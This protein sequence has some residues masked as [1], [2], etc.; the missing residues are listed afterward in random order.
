M[1]PFESRS[2]EASVLVQRGVGEHLMEHDEEEPCK[3]AHDARLLDGDCRLGRKLR[4][5]RH[6]VLSKGRPAG[7]VERLDDA[8]QRPPGAQGQAEH[9]TGDIPD[10]LRHVRREARVLRGVGDQRRLARLRYPAGDAGADRHAKLTRLRGRFAERDD[11][12]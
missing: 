1:S 3:V 8:D 6:F 9:R 12:H 7:L 5:Q 11:E 2:G 10:A 4:E